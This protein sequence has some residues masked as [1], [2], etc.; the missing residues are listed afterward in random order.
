MNPFAAKQFHVEAYRATLYSR[1]W[2]LKNKMSRRHLPGL[3]PYPPTVPVDNALD[4]RQTDASA[5]ELVM[6]VQTLKHAE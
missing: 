1:C 6:N 4:V 3:R 5:L 2:G